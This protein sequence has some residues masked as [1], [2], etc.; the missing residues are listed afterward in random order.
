MAMRRAPMEFPGRI[1]PLPR[2]IV[3]SDDWFTNSDL[4]VV[5][6]G[7]LPFAA[8]FIEIFFIMSS[9]WLHQFYYVFGFLFLVFVIL[10]VTC[11][12]ISVVMCYFHLCQENHHWYVITLLISVPLLGLLYISLHER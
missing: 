12:E 3:P 7:V 10:V 2:R 11:A 9:V 4:S 1:N 8:V 6:G 5:I